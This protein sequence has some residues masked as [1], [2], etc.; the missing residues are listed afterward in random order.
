MAPTAV[1]AVVRTARRVAAVVIPRVA[2]DIRAV[3]AVAPLSW[4]IHIGE[5]KVTG[6]T[7]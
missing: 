3:E 4:E 6:G 5:V 2:A 1:M 7:C